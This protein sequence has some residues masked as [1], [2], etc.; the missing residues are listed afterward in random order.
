MNFETEN[1]EF[2]AQ[3]TEEIYKEVI[4]FANTDGGIIYVGIDNNGNVIGLKES[5]GDNF[6]EM[7]SINQELTF[8]TASDTFQKYGVDFSKE[9][10]RV[11]G[12]THNNDSLYTNLAMIISDQ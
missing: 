1:I 7:R 2:K 9:K 3:F 8:T 6:E 12:I 4:A 5:D 10:Y 11:L